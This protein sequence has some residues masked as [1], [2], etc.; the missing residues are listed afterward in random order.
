[1]QRR[2]SARSSKTKKVEGCKE[3]NAANDVVPDETKSDEKIP[4]ANH[5]VQEETTASSSV[6]PDGAVT[7]GTNTNNEEGRN[8]ETSSEDDEHGCRCSS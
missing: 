6:V 4:T 8:Y 2:K 5:H 3:D 7:S 1:L